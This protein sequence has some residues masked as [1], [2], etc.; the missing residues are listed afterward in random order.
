MTSNAFTVDAIGDQEWNQTKGSWSL[1]K[2]T[3]SML[4]SLKS[5]QKLVTL[6][7]MIA[8]KTIISTLNRLVADAAPTKEMGSFEIVECSFQAT[9]I[10]LDTS[11]WRFLSSALRRGSSKAIYLRS[12]VDARG[13]DKRMSSLKTS[14]FWPRSS[15]QG[16]VIHNHYLHLRAP[17]RDEWWMVTDDRFTSSERQLTMTDRINITKLSVYGHFS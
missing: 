14:L 9:R 12:F 11:R 17:R 10:R 15:T 1:S 16:Q 6:W 8:I 2:T 3:T 5:G 7:S 13:L 4:R